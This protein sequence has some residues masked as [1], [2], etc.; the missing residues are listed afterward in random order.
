MAE[1]RVCLTIEEAKNIYLALKHGQPKITYP[2][3]QD[4]HLTALM[5]IRK[6]L[7]NWLKAP[8]PASEAKNIES[9]IKIIHD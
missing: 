1:D 5:T 7:E 4:R 8:E 9:V 3:S 2:E 6:V